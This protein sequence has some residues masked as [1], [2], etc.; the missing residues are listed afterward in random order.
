M[1]R[2]RTQQTEIG[3]SARG[4]IRIEQL[5]AADALEHRVAWQRQ[6]EAA[7]RKTPAHLA[8]RRRIYI[9]VLAGALPAH[10]AAGSPVVAAERDVMRDQKSGRWPGQNPQAQSQGVRIAVRRG[11]YLDEPAS[12]TV[13]PANCPGAH[14]KNR[15]Q[16]QQLPLTIDLGEDTLAVGAEQSQVA[17][18]G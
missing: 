5:I 6:A 7:A 13:Q 16:M 18:H 12:M 10:G 2:G 4:L 1:R 3:L 9:D 8:V 17:A 14:F 15:R 11:A